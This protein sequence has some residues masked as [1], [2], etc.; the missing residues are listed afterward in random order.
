MPQ[1]TAE[2]RA[3]YLKEYRINTPSNL[4]RLGR[5]RRLEMISRQ[6]TKS[7][8]LAH[9]GPERKLQCCW[10]GCPER[11]VDVL[12][13]DHIDNTGHQHRKDQPKM[14]GTTLYYWLKRNN[15][16]DGFQTLCMNHQ[17]K[18]E[19][20]RKREESKKKFHVVELTEES[21]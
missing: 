7:E 14:S 20:L 19:I 1:K 6:N 4:P 21:K 17:L 3:D 18:K 8:V 10:E 15:Y 11:D 2:E 5:N 13:I 12:S 9:Y 16:P